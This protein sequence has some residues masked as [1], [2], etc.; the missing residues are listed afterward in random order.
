MNLKVIIATLGGMIF[1]GTCVWTF[2]R[3]K[4]HLLKKKIVINTKKWKFPEN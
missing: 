3:Q 4:Y 1:G 2:D